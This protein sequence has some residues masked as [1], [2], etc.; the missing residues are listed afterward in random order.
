ML[1]ICLQQIQLHIGSLAILLQDIGRIPDP[2]LSIVSCFAIT[3]QCVRSVQNHVWFSPYCCIFNRKS[4]PMTMLFHALFCALTSQGDCSTQN[5]FWSSP[6][7]CIFK[8]KN[9][10]MTMLFHAIAH[11]PDGLLLA[12]SW[13]EDRRAGHNHVGAGTSG[14]VHSDWA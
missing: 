1:G 8:R 11:C 9:L 13:F 2:F 14:F 7:D 12:G 6:F 4:I 10:P 3:P 5:N